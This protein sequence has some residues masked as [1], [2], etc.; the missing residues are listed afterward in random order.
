[1][2]D[3]ADT[4]ALNALIAA[5]NAF[6]ERVH[7]AA[8]VQGTANAQDSTDTQGGGVSTHARTWL[9]L[10]DGMWCIDTQ[11]F[12]PWGDAAMPLDALPVAHIDT[13][14]SEIVAAVLRVLHETG[15]GAPLFGAPELRACRGM[16]QRATSGAC[17]ASDVDCAQEVHS[18]LQHDARHV[19]FVSSVESCVREAWVSK[20]FDA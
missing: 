11:V 6:V 20:F 2:A 5:H 9:A 1:M 16:L 8:D 13:T 14:F 18:L 12:L 17:D 4:T 19:H 10:L 3:G 7:G 15:G